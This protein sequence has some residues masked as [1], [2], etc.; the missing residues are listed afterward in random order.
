MGE[1]NYSDFLSDIKPLPL[2]VKQETNPMEPIQSA[3]VPI[4]CY[5][6]TRLD[7]LSPSPLW[8]TNHGL[9]KMD[10]SDLQIDQTDQSDFR[11]DQSDLQLEDDIFQVDKADLIQGPTLAELNANDDFLGDL[12][13]DDLLLPEERP[14]AESEQFQTGFGPSSF[15]QAGLGYR[16]PVYGNT[17]FGRVEQLESPNAFA[18]PGTSN[19]AGS[20]TAS[21]LSP[22]P[23]P[24]TLHTLLLRHSPLDPLV[25]PL[26]PPNSIP[27]SIH[28]PKSRLSMSAPTQV[29]LEQLWA[30]REPRPH[31]LSTGSLG[32]GLGEGST[33]SLS[34][35]ALSPDACLEG[36]SQDEGYDD[37]EEDSE[38]YDD[39]SS[40]NDSG[41]DGEESHTR[42]SGS[43]ASNSSRHA[44]KERYFW[45]YNVQSKGPKGQRLVTRTRLEDPHILNEATDPVFSPHCILR[46]IKHSG[47]ARK[48]DGNDLTPNPRKLYS[49]GRELDKLSRVIND[50]TPVAELPFS[51]RPKTRKE[52]NKLASRA[53][54]LKKKAQH[55]A[56]KIKLHGLE[57]EHKRLIQGISQ[58]KQTLAA[59]L[60]EPNP[61]NQEELTKQMEKY[62]KLATKIKIA[63]HS[64]EYVNRVLEKVRAGV[65]DGGIDEF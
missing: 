61:E 32:L 58:A 41:S 29:S 4:P 51:V 64:T 36:L 37:S 13:F 53:C 2:Q 50:M 15:P 42:I 25:S 44:K 3:S 1:S 65:P 38:H 6:N 63:N 33:S 39:Y 60:A 54:R 5:R 35:G 49:I 26:S 30:R 40:D 17:G 14:R 9:F 18:S 21:S 46:G 22:H 52:K 8:P 56:N 27:N 55:E 62:C 10:Q 57:Q 12:N 20:S 48:G 34:T 43:A 28:K 31:L 11:I 23:N 16:N 7:Q 59:K 24:S 19:V 45:Q 47:K